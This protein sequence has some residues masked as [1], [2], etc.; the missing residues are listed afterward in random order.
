MLSVIFYLAVT[1]LV[2]CLWGLAPFFLGAVPVSSQYGKVGISLVRRVRAVSAFVPGGG[3]LRGGDSGLG[4]RRPPD[5]PASCRGPVSG[6]PAGSRPAGGIPHRP[7]PD[8][9]GRAFAGTDLPY[10]A[11]RADVRQGYRLQRPVPVEP[12][13]YQPPPLR[14]ALAAGSPR[15]GGSPLRLR[16]VFG[17]RTAAA[18]KLSHSRGAGHPFLSGGPG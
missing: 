16:H 8:L 6:E 7:G 10:P 4:A 14:A 18:A 12:V 5:P 17:G 11:G 3:G 2:G 13:R 15:T 9:P 1:V